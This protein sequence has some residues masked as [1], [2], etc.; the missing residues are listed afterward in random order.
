MTGLAVSGDGTTI[1]LR[2]RECQAGMQEMDA[3]FT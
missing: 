3:G 1:V 2:G